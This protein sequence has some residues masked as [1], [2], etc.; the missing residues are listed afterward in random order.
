[1]VSAG[2]I[3]VA[4]SRCAAHAVIIREVATI[5]RIIKINAGLCG[6]GFGAMPSPSWFSVPFRYRHPREGW[7]KMCEVVH[8]RTTCTQLLHNCYDC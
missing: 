6:F 8:T 3:G 4:Q 2:G 1:M 5:A 7:G